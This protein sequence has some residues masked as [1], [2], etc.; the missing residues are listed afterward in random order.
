MAV[1][2]A[3]PAG[4]VDVTAV[5]SSSSCS[6]GC[7]PLRTIFLLDLLLFLARDR[8]GGGLWWV[9]D[10]SFVVRPIPGSGSIVFRVVFGLWAFGP[11]GCKR[12]VEKRIVRNGVK[13]H[14][15][16]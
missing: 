14:A 12:D 4:L 3:T 1:W 16:L 8:G 5:G 10:D 13:Q 9:D 15:P 6:C 11:S 2:L 7:R